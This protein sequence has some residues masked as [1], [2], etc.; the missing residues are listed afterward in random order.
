MGSILS[1]GRDLELDCANMEK[2]VN[3]LDYYEIRNTEIAQ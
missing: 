1:A 2:P 3:R